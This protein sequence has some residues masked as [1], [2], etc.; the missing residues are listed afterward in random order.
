MYDDQRDRK[1][2][3]FHD[4]LNMTRPYVQQGGYM[5]AGL[6]SADAVATCYIHRSV[7]GKA[8]YTFILHIF[9]SGHFLG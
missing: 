3:D 7:V 4:Q 6:D 5:V 9:A 1:K 2:H 8:Y